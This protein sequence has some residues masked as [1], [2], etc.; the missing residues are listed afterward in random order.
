MAALG[1]RFLTLTVDSTER[2]PECS[3][4]SIE[5]AEATTDFVSFADAAAGGSREYTLQITMVQD[6]VAASLWDEIFSHA[7]DTV[8]VVVRPY[9]NATASSSQP[10]FHGNVVISEPDGTL[11]GGDADKSTTQRWTTQV[12]WAF[13]AKPTRVV[14]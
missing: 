7:G 13:T 2:A 9:G 14:T 1:T 8:A 11:I 4:V 12:A 3:H 10:H 6:A 5:S